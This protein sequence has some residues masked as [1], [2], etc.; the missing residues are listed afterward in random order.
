MKI[1]TIV[2]VLSLPEFILS[3]SPSKTSN[4]ADVSTAPPTTPH[5]ISIKL[6]QFQKMEESALKGW[7]D[8]VNNFL[9]IIKPDHKTIG[10]LHI[11]FYC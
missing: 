6:E 8:M 5:P 11:H 1:L 4:S 10:M 7:Y 2:L 9:N 3:V